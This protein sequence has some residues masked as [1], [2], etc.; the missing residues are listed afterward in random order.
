MSRFKV[1]E[2]EIEEEPVKENSQASLRPPSF[3]ASEHVEHYRNHAHSPDPL[4]F[5]AAKWKGLYNQAEDRLD[6]GAEESGQAYEEAVASFQKLA[7]HL[8]RP[9]V[10]LLRPRG[11]AGD[12]LDY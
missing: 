2:L 4:A 11:Q 5:L 8:G 1:R 3:S 12:F 6:I 10:R 9:K 7:R